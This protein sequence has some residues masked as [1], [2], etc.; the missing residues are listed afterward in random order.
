MTPQEIAAVQ[1]V[2]PGPPVAARVPLNRQLFGLCPF[3]EERSPSF[4]VDQR[5]NRF[6]RF[7]CGADGDAITWLMKT[8]GLDF[9]SAVAQLAN[10]TSSAVP[11]QYPLRRPLEPAASSFS[12]DRD[13]ALAIWRAA[14]PCAPGTGAWNYLHL[15]GIAHNIP[16]S[17]R[18]HPRLFCAETG[19]HFPALIA[20]LKD[21]QHGIVAV[22]R[23]W[24]L[25]R[26]A[27][28]GG[29][30]SPAG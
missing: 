21:E 25:D 16:P 28:N 18:A 19:G 6:H 26:V 20:A 7:G 2:P 13:K 9:L 23:I 1:A 3:H 22:Q 8:A 4:H 10:G 14:G 11:P 5:R 30:D 12:G 17:L 24:C 15:R 27:F 29:P